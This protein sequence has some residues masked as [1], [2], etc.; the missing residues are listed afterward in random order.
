MADEFSFRIDRP[1]GLVRITMSGFNTQADI[2]AFV[3]GPYLARTQIQRALANRVSKCF[4]DPVAAE[5]WLLAGD[6]EIA[7]LRRAA[8]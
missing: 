1:L 5:A 3:V 6:D 8:G 7:P 2:R 4:T